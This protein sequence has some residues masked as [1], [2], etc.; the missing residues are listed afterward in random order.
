M[1]GSKYKVTKEEK[2]Y[3]E[4]WFSELEIIFAMNFKILKK[5]FKQYF[6]N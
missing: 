6:S 2:I 1:A 3:A 5:Y 4:S